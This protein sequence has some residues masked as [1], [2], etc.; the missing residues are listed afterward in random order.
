MESLFFCKINASNGQ[1][2]IVWPARTSFWTHNHRMKAGESILLKVKAEGHPVPGLAWQ[3]VGAKKKREKKQDVILLQFLT[4]LRAKFARQIYR[5]CFQGR[6]YPE[7]YLTEK[8]QDIS[9]IW[10]RPDRILEIEQ[11]LFRLG[12]N[13]NYLW[14][15]QEMLRIVK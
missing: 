15:I 9:L 5:S 11:M 8:S 13:E 14:H 3:K 4:C 7:I 6:I 10:N 12:Q 1:K 2:S